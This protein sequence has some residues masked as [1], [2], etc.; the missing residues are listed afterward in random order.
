MCLVE[1][2]LFEFEQ[3]EICLLFIIF[4]ATLTTTI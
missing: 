4:Y 2:Y 3:F 1:N